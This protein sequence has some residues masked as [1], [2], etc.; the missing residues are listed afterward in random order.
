MEYFNISDMN[1][2]SRDP[3]EFIRWSQERYDAKVEAAALQILEAA[4]HGK[5]LVLL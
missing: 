1:E 4:E 5:P 3:A 2:A